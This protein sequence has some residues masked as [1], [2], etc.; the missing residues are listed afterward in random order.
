M[1]STYSNGIRIDYQQNNVVNIADVDPN[2]NLEGG[3]YIPQQFTTDNGQKV[4]VDFS[5]I[6]KEDVYKRQVYADPGE[7]CYMP[8]DTIPPTPLNAWATSY[9]TVKVSFDEPVDASASIKRCRRD[10]EMC[11]RDRNA[12]V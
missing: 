8:G 10:S 4:N 7:G 12:I 1:H 9:T 11:I 5:Y 3:Q 6:T 2:L